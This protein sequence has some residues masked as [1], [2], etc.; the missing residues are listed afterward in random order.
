MKQIL[1]MQNPIQTYA[2]GS[3]TAIA[4]LMGEAVPSEEP[5]AEMWMGAHPKSPSRVWYQERWQ[6]LDKLIASHPLEMLSARWSS[7]AGSSLN[8]LVPQS[9]S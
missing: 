8:G 6:R 4:R 1:S 2:W 5:Q 3:H 7:T 9:S